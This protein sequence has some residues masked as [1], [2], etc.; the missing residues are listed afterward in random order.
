[1]RKLTW[2]IYAGLIFLACG[3]SRT[4]GPMAL[5]KKMSPH[6]QYA[7]RLKDAGLDRTA[8]GAAWIQKASSAFTNVLNVIL[9]YKELGYFE[10]SKVNATALRFEAKRGQKLHIA[11]SKKP[12]A[13]FTIFTDL[14]QERTGDQPKLLAS[15]DTTSLRLDYDID[16]TGKYIVR[17][18]PE[19]LR[20]GEY[21]LTI[22]TGPSLGFP[23]AA[24]GKPH[25]ESFWGAARDAGARR[26]EGIDIFAPKGTPAVAA[27]NGTVTSVTENKLGGLVVFMR[28]Q[29]KDYTLYY[30]HLSKQLARDGQQVRVGD[31]LGFVGNTGNA[32]GGPTHLHFGIYAFGGAIDPIYFVDRDMKLPRPITGNTNL[33]NATVRLQRRSGLF[34]EPDNVSHKKLDLPANTILTAEAAT[35]NWFRVATPEGETGF[36][37]GRDVESTKETD[38]LTI[39]LATALLDAPASS[40]SRKKQLAEGDRVEV[41]GRYHNYN[42][43]TAGDTTGWVLMK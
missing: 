15:I 10:G 19:L 38:R 41:L 40:A 14:W 8:M 42:L 37:P 20:G 11:L 5:F 2:A 43:V 36:I 34:T 24:A 22:T 29:D 39:R 3:C 23:V 25:I 21:T 13:G 33:L 26:H 30:A 4:S 12:A 6:D 27:A 28:P 7:Q 18:Q 31:T 1:M 32:A 9:P 17:L 16:E 35:D